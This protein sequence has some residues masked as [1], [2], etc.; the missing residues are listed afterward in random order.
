M[1]ENSDDTDTIFETVTESFEDV[2]TKK[3]NQSVKRK[4]TI[5]SKSIFNDRKILTLGD[6][7][8]NEDGNCS[9]IHNCFKDNFQH[10]IKLLRCSVVK[11]VE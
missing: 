1:V 11:T 10:I 7:I 6:G 9:I 5:K 2:T 4:Y 3:K 8:V